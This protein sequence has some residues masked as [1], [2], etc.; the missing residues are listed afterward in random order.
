M[1]GIL[2]RLLSRG[3]NEL[4]MPEHIFAGQPVR[5]MVELQNEKLTCIVLLR[6]E[7]A[8]PKGTTAPAAMLETPVIPVSPKH[9]RVQQTVP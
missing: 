4:K 2:L 6:V 9:D 8:K 5:A 7:A 1:S 3:S